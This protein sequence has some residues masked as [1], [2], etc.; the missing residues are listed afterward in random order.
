LERTADNVVAGVF[1]MSFSAPH[2][3]G[4]RLDAFER[5]LRRLLRAVSP[6]GRFSERQPGAE[7]FIWR[8]D[9]GSA[10]AGR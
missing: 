4:T 8:N 7:M 1:S 10:T 5:E 3:F 6:S 2:L 9:P